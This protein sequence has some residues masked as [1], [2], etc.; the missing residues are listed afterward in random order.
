MG[1]LPSGAKPRCKD[2]T[3]GTR[4]RQGGTW[5]TPLFQ[6]KLL[7]PPAEHLRCK[8]RAIEPNRYFVRV[9]VRSLAWR[10]TPQ[11]AD[12]L[13]IGADSQNATGDG[14]GHVE[15]VDA[16]RRKSSAGNSRAALS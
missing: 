7:G 14:V 16:A 11:D 3:W 1:D 10:G 13:A 5:G 8:Y 12:D 4:T 6:A 15:E 9:E 2:G